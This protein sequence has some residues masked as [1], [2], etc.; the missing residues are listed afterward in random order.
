[1]TFYAFEKKIFNADD[2]VWYLDR[3]VC[4]LIYKE[5][6]LKFYLIVW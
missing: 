6:S 4:W 5:I 3:Y 2:G 1:V